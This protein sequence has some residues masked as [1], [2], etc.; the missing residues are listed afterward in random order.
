MGGIK[1]LLLAWE[2]IMTKVVLLLSGL[3]RHYKYYIALERL[4]FKVERERE[5]DALVCCRQGKL[6]GS[7]LPM[8]S[9]QRINFIVFNNAVVTEKQLH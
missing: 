6:L 8:N 3:S 2:M 4:E 7:Q 9:R 1:I 5:R